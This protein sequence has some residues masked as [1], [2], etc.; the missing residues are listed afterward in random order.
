MRCWGWVYCMDDERIMIAGVL[1]D[2]GRMI[3]RM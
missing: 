1:F 2:E 3:R